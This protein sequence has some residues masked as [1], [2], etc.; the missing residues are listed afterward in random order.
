LLTASPLYPLRYPANRIF[1][2]VF[3]KTKKKR[4]VNMRKGARIIEIK[5]NFCPKSEIN[6]KIENQEFRP[7]EVSERSKER[8]DFFL[9]I[10]A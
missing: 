1:Q 5:Q 8:R 7:G 3:Y 6:I 2:R 4:P 9:A 10:L